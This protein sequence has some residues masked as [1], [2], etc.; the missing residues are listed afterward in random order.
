[1]DLG[2]LIYQYREEN[3]L[4]QRQFSA[5]CGISNGLI[6]IIE[7]GINPNSGKPIV[8]KLE[9]LYKIAHGMSMSIDELLSKIGDITLSMDSEISESKKRL[10]DVIPLLPDSVSD[11]LLILAEQALQGQ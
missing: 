4:S 9:T 2:E 7:R 6:S 1:M 10:L 8:P 11:A 3:G 5:K